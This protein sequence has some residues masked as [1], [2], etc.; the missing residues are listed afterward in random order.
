MYFLVNGNKPERIVKAIKN[1]KFEG[2]LFRVKI[3][4]SEEY[5]ILVDQIMTIL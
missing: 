4:W 3:K 2:T 1:K 5:L